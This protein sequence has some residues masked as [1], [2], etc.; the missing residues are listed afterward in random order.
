MIRRCVASRFMW[1]CLSTGR[2]RRSIRCQR[3]FWI[4]FANAACVFESG[5]LSKPPRLWPSSLRSPRTPSPPCPVRADEAAHLRSSAAP[6]AD[7]DLTWNKLPACHVFS[8]PK[9]LGCH[10]TMASW[11]LTPR[12]ITESQGHQRRGIKT[13]ARSPLSIR[14]A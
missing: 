9:S 10:S 2:K 1:T 6:S 13:M 3:P 12:R 5:L 8:L 4:I 14:I 11:K 7:I